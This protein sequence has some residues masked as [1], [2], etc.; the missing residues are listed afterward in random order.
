MFHPYFKWCYLYS[1]FR[2]SCGRSN[3]KIGSWKYLAIFLARENFWK[4]LGE[5]TAQSNASPPSHSKMTAAKA[6][7]NQQVIKV[8]A[9]FLINITRTREDLSKFIPNLCTRATHH[10]LLHPNKP[11]ILSSQLGNIQIFP[12]ELVSKQ[13]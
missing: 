8:H 6:F 3:I 7:Q 12:R 13:H 2:K 11:T 1:S 5:V 4:I 9:G 10:S